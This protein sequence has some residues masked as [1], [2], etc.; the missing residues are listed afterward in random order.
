MLVFANYQRI[1][2]FQIS[3]NQNLASQIAK[4]N[5]SYIRFCEND[6]NISL[7]LQIDNLLISLT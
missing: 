3:S 1:I 6:H 7:S 4:P 5:S 2:I